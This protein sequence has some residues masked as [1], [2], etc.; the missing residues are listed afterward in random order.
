MSLCHCTVSSYCNSQ[1]KAEI[2]WSFSWRKMQL[3]TSELKEV[4]TF[5]YIGTVLKS[6]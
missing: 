1:R 2:K 4:A 5:D 3:E 6:K